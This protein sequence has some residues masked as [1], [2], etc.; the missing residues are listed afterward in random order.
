M[1]SSAKSLDAVRARELYKYFR[2]DPNTSACHEGGLV[3]SQATSPD[4][5]LTAYAQLVAWRLNCQRAMISLIDRET[6]YFVAESTKTLNF[7]DNSR[8]TDPA[9]S[10]WLGCSSVSKEGRLC[11]RTIALPPSNGDFPCFQITDLK[12]DPTFCNLPFVS[13]EPGFRFY[14]GTPITTNKGV[15]IGS[16]FVLDDKPHPPLDPLEIEF[17]GHMAMIIMQHMQL[18]RD[19]SERRRALQMQ[20]GLSVFVESGSSL[21]RGHM[22]RSTSYDD[23]SKAEKKSSTLENTRPS[24]EGLTAPPPSTGDI[25]N[26]QTTSS[27]DGAL[28]EKKN[29]NAQ[30]PVLTEN[31]VYKDPVQAATSQVPEAEETL[32]QTFSRAAN[33]LHESLFEGDGGVIFLSTKPG[34]T[35]NDTY[36]RSGLETGDPATQT[37]DGT[38]SVGETPGSADNVSRATW[39]SGTTRDR[40]T[41]ILGARFPRKG[42][43]RSFIPVGEAMIASLVKRY[44]SGKLWLADEDGVASSSEEE[45]TNGAL[46][47]PTSEEQLSR[48]ARRRAKE[49]ILLKHF[50]GARSLLFVPLWDAK[51]G[52]WFSACFCWS[53]NPLTTFTYETEVLYTVAFGNCVMS[54]VSRLESMAADQSKTNF[55]GSISH[56]LRSPLH[57]ILASN[58]FLEQTKCD[59]F[60]Q[61]LVE[62]ISACG[63]TLLDTINHVL[64]FS[65]INS[66]VKSERSARKPKYSK[67]HGRLAERGLIKSNQGPLNIVAEI[68]LAKV[69][70][71]VVCGIY[72]GHAFRDMSKEDQAYLS[73]GGT[74]AEGQIM[75]RSEPDVDIILDIAPHDWTFITQPGAFRRICMNLL[76]NALKYTEKGYVKVKLEATKLEDSSSQTKKE[77]VKLI[78]SDTG[79]GISSDYLRTKLF[80]PFS[81]ENHLAPGTGLGLSIVKTVVQLLE[82]HIDVRS[83]IGKGSEFTI[84]LPLS[85]GTSTNDSPSTTPSSTNSAPGAG[86]T[87]P[88]VVAAVEEDG[89]GL[90][91]G[92]LPPTL[93]SPG[94]SIQTRA[95]SLIQDSM[96]NYITNWFH[97]NVV[98]NTP[99]NP[100]VSI[101]IIDES[102]LS[103]FS[104]VTLNHMNNGLTPALLVLCRNGL[105][106]SQTP[107][108]FNDGRVIEYLTQPFGAQKL[109]KALL[110][111]FSRLKEMSTIPT[112]LP[113]SPETVEGNVV[114]I[115][116]VPSV[117]AA[118]EMTEVVLDGSHVR[119]LDNGVALG[120]EDSLNASRALDYHPPDYDDLPENKGK[121]FPFVA[122]STQQEL[123]QASTEPA[124]STYSTATTSAPFKDHPLAPQSISQVLHDPIQPSEERE[125]SSERDDRTPTLSPSK[126][127]SPKVLLVDDNQINLRL[128]RTFMKKRKYD[129][130]DMAVDG[131][132]AV[133]A[134]KKT[135]YDIIFMDISMPRLNGFEATSQ[136]REL[137]EER[138]ATHLRS[139]QAGPS[140]SPAF[141]IALT[142]LASSKDQKEAFEVGIDL[143]MTKPVVFKEVG[144]LL[145]NWEQNR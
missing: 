130:V 132:L 87:E 75:N 110:V 31:V 98:S 43:S 20:K 25:V 30:P 107:K 121:E 11:E 60:Q 109:A 71:E 85:R 67:R 47:G 52:R 113:I 139:D 61:S 79:K 2:P 101:C 102:M 10:L 32:S 26:P 106:Y 51:A 105:Q 122:E 58:E 127:F 35:G 92:V 112:G 3:A 53:L 56:E 77:M 84:T 42:S 59:P 96:L 9:D 55:I 72:A 22:S 41:D 133:E 108:V 131:F 89:N 114:N 44:P 144:K 62:T 91:I 129:L 69:L 19:A 21:E 76:G 138:R 50:S 16:L 18:A 83:Q 14:A 48:K 117:S 120:R 86:A 28:V 99:L 128:L 24:A 74:S 17:L 45:A 36:S 49:N 29:A 135:C 134:A 81:Q 38:V 124:V 34:I 116:S 40:S 140:P 15:N 88:D 136:I 33:I 111:L 94:S 64:D 65:K 13:G 4:T 104:A 66:L 1:A 78:V 100:P 103:S 123:D 137:E 143:F 6:Q 97:L 23:L 115:S 119:L 126:S 70:E 68:D 82:G 73:R 142:G 39:G 63:K 125:E 80:V 46:S 5:A 27:D 12:E 57:G 8:H 7:Y 95:S 118:R 93:F 37:G 90:S 145:D 54:E 141:I